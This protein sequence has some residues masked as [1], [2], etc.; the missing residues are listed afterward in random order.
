VIRVYIAVGSPVLRAGLEALLQPEPAITVTDQEPDVVV[1]DRP[2]IPEVPAAS[3]LLSD[4]PRL[5]DIH[6][7]IRSVLPRDVT[8]VELV[9]ALHAVAAGLVVLHPAALVIPASDFVD[10]GP[11]TSRE[12][13]ILGMLAEGLPNKNIA[14]KLDISEHTVKFHVASIL[15]KLGV[16]SRTEAVTVGLRRGLIFL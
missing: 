15:S 12:V 4:S 10:T 3:I 6:P 8:P 9:A 14:W 7:P 11:L 1:T 16:S 13:E 2:D 5:D